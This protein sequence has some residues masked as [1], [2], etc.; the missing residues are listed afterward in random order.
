MLCHGASTA[1]MSFPRSAIAATLREIQPG[2]AG[3]TR[4]TR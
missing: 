1:A 3:K 4:I 2:M